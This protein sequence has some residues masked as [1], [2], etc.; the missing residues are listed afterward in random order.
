MPTAPHTA[1]ACPAS[2]D[3][4]TLIAS[5]RSVGAMLPD[6]PPRASIELMLEAATYAP[7]HR[8]TEP[9][10]FH[11]LTGDARVQLAASA[12]EAMRARGEPE[13][14]VAKARGSFTR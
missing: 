8:R 10:S 14:A 13:A 1:D 2:A 5:R 9:W 6:A 12:A 7:N 4:M 11:V 3:V